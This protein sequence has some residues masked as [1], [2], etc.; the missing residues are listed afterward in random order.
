M[1]GKGGKSK[2]KKKLKKE[3]EKKSGNIREAEVEAGQHLQVQG[4]S[5]L[6]NGFLDSQDFIESQ[7]KNSNNNKRQTQIC[8]AFWHVPT[9]PDTLEAG[10]G[11]F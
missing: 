10:A 2:K 7:R 11:G 4:Q 1:L 8:R 6:H 3:K 9:N 5:G